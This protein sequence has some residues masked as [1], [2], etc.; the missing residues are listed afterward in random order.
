MRT[1]SVFESYQNCKHG[2]VSNQLMDV[3]RKG[4]ACWGRNKSV[5]RWVLFEPQNLEVSLYKTATFYSGM[6][7]YDINCTSL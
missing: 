2:A 6:F 5:V 7:K 3:R 4:D 1:L